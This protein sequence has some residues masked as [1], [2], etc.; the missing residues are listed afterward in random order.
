MTCEHCVAKVEQALKGVSG[1][2]GAFV[3]LAEGVAEVDFD[4][5]RAQPAA[6][7][8]AVKAAGYDA[9]VSA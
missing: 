9:Q 3:D 1:V 6:L 5:A 7:V 4:D 2:W 8:E